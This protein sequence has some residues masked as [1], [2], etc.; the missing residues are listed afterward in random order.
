MIQVVLG[1]KVFRDPKGT[2]DRLDPLGQLARLELKEIPA[3]LDLTELMER[4]GLK[5]FRV[6][7]GLKETLVVLEQPGPLAQPHTQ[8]QA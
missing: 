1:R 5:G 3:Q 6:F 7:R 8:L 4:K 2:L